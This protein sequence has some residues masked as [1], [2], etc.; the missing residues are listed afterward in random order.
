MLAGQTSVMPREWNAKGYDALPLPHTAWGTGVLDRLAA[1]RLPESARVLDAGCGTGRDAAAARERWPAMRIA[2]LDG[3]EQMLAQARTKLGETAEYMHAD[4]MQPLSIDPVDAVMSVAAFHWVP[5]HAALFANLVAVMRPGAPLVTDCGG[6]GNIAGVNQ[7]LARVTGEATT[8][9]E[10]ADAEQTTTRLVAAGF[11][12]R[13]VR[14][15][16]GPFRCED[17]EILE[18]YLAAV[19]L[20]SHLDRL[21][22]G[23]HDSF[24]REV[25][26]ALPAPEV[27]Y[28]RLEIDAVRR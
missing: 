12:V 3:S 2:L 11:D 25:R 21:P 8:P 20:G 19:V 7:A 9:W 6:A 14:L 26:D 24:V 10:F 15:R 5:D 22:A 17:P 28:V 16:P 18:Q 4:L 27:D 23:E 13:D 1:H